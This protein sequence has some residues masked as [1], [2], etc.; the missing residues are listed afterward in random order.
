[1]EGVEG[2]AADFGKRDLDVCGRIA[3]RCRDSE[4]EWSGEA[5]V[6]E[7]GEVRRSRMSSG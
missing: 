4:S 1:V 6:S 2:F 3:G 7:I 5:F